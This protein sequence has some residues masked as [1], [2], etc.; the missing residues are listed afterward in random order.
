MPPQDT[1]APTDPSDSLQG[2]ALP[3]GHLV[4]AVLNAVAILNYLSETAYAVTAAELSRSLALTR[5]HCHS[6]LRTLVQAGWVRFD[7]RTKSYELNSGLLANAAA[8]SARLSSE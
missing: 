8:R 4:P 2:W 7:G 3:T 1:T 6:V 5:S